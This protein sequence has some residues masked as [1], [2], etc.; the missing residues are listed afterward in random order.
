M[1]D[2]AAST[3]VPASWEDDCDTRVLPSVTQLERSPEPASI[4]AEDADSED[5]HGPQLAG[6]APPA[7]PVA[8]DAEF[9]ETAYLEAAGIVSHFQR[10][11]EELRVAAGSARGAAEIAEADSALAAM[12]SH[13]DAL[14]PDAAGMEASLPGG[15]IQG[16]QDDGDDGDDTAPL[17][18]SLPWLIVDIAALSARLNGVDPTASDEVAATAIAQAWGLLLCGVEEPLHSIPPPASRR[19]GV[20]TRGGGAR[21]SAGTASTAARGGAAAGDS[22]RLRLPSGFV[23]RAP[24]SDPAALLVVGEALLSVRLPMAGLATSP[25]LSPAAL[26]GDWE[27]AVDAFMASGLAF[28]CSSDSAEADLSAMWRQR[29]QQQ[30]ERASHSPT[31]T[32]PSAAAPCL[33]LLPYPQFAGLPVVGVRARRTGRD[34]VPVSGVATA[35]R[36]L[37]ERVST[38]LTPAHVAA[39]R[40]KAAAAAAASSLSATASSTP[41]VASSSRQP[42]S[43]FVPGAGA[44]V[45]NSGAAAVS[46]DEQRELEL[47]GAAAAVDALRGVVEEAHR[48]L[49]W[50]AALLDAVC[51]LLVGAVGARRAQ[52]GLSLPHTAVPPTVA[53]PSSPSPL[54]IMSSSSATTSW[55]AAH[56]AA[57]AASPLVRLLVPLLDRAPPPQRTDSPSGEGGVGEGEVGKGD[58]GDAGDLAWRRAAAALHCAAVSLSKQQ[59]HTD[60]NGNSSR[61]TS[62]PSND[63][64][65]TAAEDVPSDWCVWG[66]PTAADCFDLWEAAFGELPGVEGVLGW[67]GGDGEGAGGGQQQFPSWPPPVSSAPAP[68]GSSSASSS[69]PPLLLPSP[70]GVAGD[71]PVIGRTTATTPHVF[72]ATAAPPPPNVAPPAPAELL[73]PGVLLLMQAAGYYGG[74]S[75]GADAASPTGAAAV[76]SSSA[77]VGWGRSSGMGVAALASLRGG[78][79]GGSGDG[80]GGDSSSSDGDDSD[81][82]GGRGC[83]SGLRRQTQRPPARRPR[84]ARAAASAASDAGEFARWR[85]Q[86]RSG[87][88]AVSMPKLGGLGGDGGGGTASPF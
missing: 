9:A 68:I 2:E 78:G 34:G 1:A 55:R 43:R 6:S 16:S 4:N 27:T 65:P 64:S 10:T 21:C 71:V 85:E 66:A 72:H 51:A 69:A 80:G 86:L 52:R 13:L 19:V 44:G 79:G 36:A 33:A 59:G 3:T 31:R 74:Y 54:A 61:R 56:P 39:M 23:R 81:N 11:I 88:L 20:V 53:P 49:A 73:S 18:A 62:H 45:G 14:R 75:E 83:S 25:T 41:T 77:A 42:P 40:R 7:P 70:E 76:S 12:Q 50:K 29:Q 46:V 8:L 28:H 63:D 17:P 82:E 22:L 24:D 48:G 37:W 87:N 15:A 30:W 67:G 84:R 38:P 58:A 57:L 32:V 5:G 26:C 35:P 60:E 47:E